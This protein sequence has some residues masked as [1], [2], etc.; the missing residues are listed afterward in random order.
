LLQTLSSLWSFN[1]L[2]SSEVQLIIVRIFREMIDFFFFFSIYICYCQYLVIVRACLFVFLTLLNNVVCKLLLCFVFFSS[3]NLICFFF[4]LY[5]LN[6]L[7]SDLYFFPVFLFLL[8]FLVWCFLRAGSL[9]ISFLFR[10]L[11]ALSERL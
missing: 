5:G 7:Y 11:V 8:V 6:M 2:V 9:C 3:A 10:T 4:L 1:L